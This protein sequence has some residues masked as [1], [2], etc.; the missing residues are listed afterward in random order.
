MAGE[1]P[2]AIVV[3]IRQTAHLINIKI[4]IKRECWVWQAPIT[5]PGI[6]DAIVLQ[7]VAGGCTPKGGGGPFFTHIPVFL[8]EE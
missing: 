1:K 5:V 7:V 3:C 4:N 6:P 8:S 2:E